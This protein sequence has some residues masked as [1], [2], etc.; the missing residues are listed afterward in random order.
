MARGGGVGHPGLPSQ[1]S[2]HHQP[3][4]VRSLVAAPLPV[5]S[6][7]SAGLAALRTGTNN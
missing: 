4:L 7:T 2:P 1:L 3:S 5:P 6:P